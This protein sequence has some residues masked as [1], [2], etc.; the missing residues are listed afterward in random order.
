MDFY[1]ANSLIINSA[2]LLYGFL[3]FLGRRNYFFILNIILTETGVI[4]NNDSKLKKKKLDTSTY[5]KIDW[6]AIRKKMRLPFF[7]L[8]KKWA[9]KF[10]SENRIKS[11]FSQEEINTFI[12]EIT[13]EK[14]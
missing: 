3:V 9:I 12:T 8:P 4:D 13:P 1:L 6:R 2:V 7:T 5:E 11:V 10:N 14:E